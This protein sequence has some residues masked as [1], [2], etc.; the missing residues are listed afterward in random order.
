MQSKFCLEKGH[1]SQRRGY[2]T[3]EVLTWRMEPWQGEQSSNRVKA[4]KSDLPGLPRRPLLKAV[5]DARR[6]GVLTFLK[7]P[8]ITLFS[9]QLAMRLGCVNL[10]KPELNRTQTSDAIS[11]QTVP[12]FRI[13][14]H[15]SKFITKA[16]S[17]GPLS[18]G[19]YKSLIL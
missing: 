19:R 10:H 6:G 4:V 1:G 12:A 7:T 11:R 17:N 15:R 18:S 16:C 8:M 3:S 2:T 14:Q 9:R 13:Y 5:S